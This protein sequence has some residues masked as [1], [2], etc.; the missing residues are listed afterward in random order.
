[1]GSG[2]LEVFCIDGKWDGRV[3]FVDL[4]EDFNKAMVFL[5]EFIQG[6]DSVVEV[7]GTTIEHR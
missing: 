3:G 4:G 2:R 1:M 5:D 6:E 7:V